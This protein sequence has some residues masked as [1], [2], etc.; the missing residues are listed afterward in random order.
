MIYPNSALQIL[1][2]I[3][4][5]IAALHFLRGILETIGLID[6]EIR[7]IRFIISGAVIAAGCGI[8]SSETN[9]LMEAPAS[10]QVVMNVAEAVRGQPEEQLLLA[11]FQKSDF[12]SYREV[13]A[14]FQA[15]WAR[16]ERD[17]EK[18][19]L[20]ALESLRARSRELPTVA[21]SQRGVDAESRESQVS[22]EGGDY[23]ETQRPGE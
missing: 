12:P 6:G 7:C 9:R 3:V 15:K 2:L 4:L 18:A 8:L 1:V 22:G 17:K 19:K 13:N 20:A 14:V 23:G 10:Q 21:T 11:A 5:L 16:Q